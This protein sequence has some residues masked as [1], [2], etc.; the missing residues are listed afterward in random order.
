MTPEERARE[1]VRTCV[2][3]EFAENN[4]GIIQLGFWPGG[5]R[6]GNPFV[7]AD[8]TMAVADELRMELMK[9]YYEDLKSLQ[10]QLTFGGIDVILKSLRDLLYN[11]M[12]AYF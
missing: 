11:A 9:C 3:Q 7:T 2:T 5:D 10:K 4:P 1:S 12:G 8:V 6:D